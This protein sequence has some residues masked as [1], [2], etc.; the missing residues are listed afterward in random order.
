MKRQKVEMADVT[1]D[2]T[3]IVYDAKTGSIRHVHQVLTLKGG[4]KPK[5]SEIE[6]R[7]LGFTAEQGIKASQVA[8][9]VVSSDQLPPGATY[10]I[11]TKKQ[12]IVS[13]PIAVPAERIKKKV[14]SQR[15]KRSS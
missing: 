7:A 1:S 10:R 2:T 11:D 15:T 8:T 5:P 4:A 13:K 6:K 9:L 3:C 14:K 12:I